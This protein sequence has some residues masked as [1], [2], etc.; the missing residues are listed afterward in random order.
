V[1]APPPTPVGGGARGAGAH[2]ARSGG[3]PRA[4][5]PRAMD[6]KLAERHQPPTNQAVPQQ[7]VP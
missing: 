3:E 5:P 1:T 4:H 6:I 2:T 7:T